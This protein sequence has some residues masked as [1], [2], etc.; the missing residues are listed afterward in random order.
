MD[1]RVT[2]QINNKSPQES[3]VKSLTSSQIC[4]GCFSIE[5]IIETRRQKYKA[6]KITQNGLRNGIIVRPSVCS[7]CGKSGKIH[8]HH[9]DYSK[10]LEIMWLCP[11]CHGTKR[12]R[13]NQ[14]YV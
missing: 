14:S 1:V 9:E 3:G 12:K 6:R 5:E 11:R 13:K 7:V 2:N 10:P 4:G 8:A